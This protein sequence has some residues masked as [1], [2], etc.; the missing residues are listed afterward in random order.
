M[1]LLTVHFLFNLSLLIV[2]LFFCFMWAEKSGSIRFYK[3]TSVLYF[4]GSLLLCYVFS[5][6]L[7]GELVLDLRIVP[8][9][10]GG[11]YM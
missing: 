11:L 1:Q 9:M 4:V 3:G 5:F 10:I 2:L 6:R 7:N 8:F